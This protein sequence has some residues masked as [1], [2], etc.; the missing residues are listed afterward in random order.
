MK[1]YILPCAAAWA[2]LALAAACHAQTPAASANG[3]PTYPAKAIR[4]I[5]PFPPGQAS[6]VLARA[7]GAKLTE[8]FHQQVVV[9]NRPGAG[10]NIG[11]DQAAKAPPDGYTLVMATAALPISKSVYAK[12]PFDPAKD[13]APVTM[14]TKTPLVLIVNP[15]LPVKSVKE[16]VALAK[17]KPGALS[18]ASSGNG[19]SH[20]LSGELFKVTA[21]IDIVHVPYK[22]SAPAQMDII[23]GQV[24]MMFDNI[25]AVLPNVTSGKLKGLAV[26]TPHRWFALPDLPTMAE[27][28][29]PGVE[30][31]AWFGVLAPAGTP[32]QVIATLNREIGRVIALPEIKDRFRTQGIELA[33]STPADM[34]KFMQAEIV[35]WAKVVQASGAH[36]D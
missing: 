15:A 32:P 9:D 3:T 28:G 7:I 14:L 26:T 35:K 5:V 17:A 27:S 1:R 19:T 22:G 21:G 30:A 23:G 13:F 25:V 12:L 16:L 34:Q 29:L 36:A 24:A 11:S 18:F 10:G 31:V 20:Q 8:A 4:L 33:G 6:D 2:A